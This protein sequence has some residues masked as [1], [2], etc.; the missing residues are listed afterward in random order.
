MISTIN[1]KSKFVKVVEDT[2]AFLE[3]Q[4]PE[5]LQSRLSFLAKT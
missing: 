1:T 2:T 5:F 4:R 3:G